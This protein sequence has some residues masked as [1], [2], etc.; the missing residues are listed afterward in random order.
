MNVNVLEFKSNKY[1]NSCF[2]ERSNLKNEE[3]EETDSIE[4]FG[5]TILLDEEM[6][7]EKA[8]V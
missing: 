5:Y 8:C 6:N 1:C 7:H 3:K 2:N 4:F